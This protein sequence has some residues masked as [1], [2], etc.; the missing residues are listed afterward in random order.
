MSNKCILI[1]SDTHSPYH[2]PDLIPFLKAIKKK[3]KPDRIVHIGDETDKHGLNFHGQDP[4][5]PSAGD[6]LYEARE[7]I[8]DIEKLWSNVDLLHSNHGSLAYRRAF[9]AGLP[10]AYMRDYNEV[11]EVG[12]G[13]NGIM[14]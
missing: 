3:Y 10:K 2:H 7:T 14:S 5:L 1:I 13:W 9:K 8:H 12:K 11:L 4:D 6:E